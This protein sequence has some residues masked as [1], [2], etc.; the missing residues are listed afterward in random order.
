MKEVLELLWAPFSEVGLY[1]EIRAIKNGL[2]NQFFMPTEEPELHEAYAQEQSRLGFDVYF[3]VLPRVR[4]SGTAG[5]CV[6]TSAVLWSDVDAKRFGAGKL[7]ALQAV[8]DLGPVPQVLVDSGGG[9]HAYWLLAEPVPFDQARRAME[10]IAQA[11][12]G[13]ATYDA[14]RV[15][16]VPGTV[17]YKYRNY[18]RVLRL[19]ATAPR[20]RISDFPVIEMRP[21]PN[22]PVPKRPSSQQVDW[23]GAHEIPKWLNVLIEKG[24]PRGQRSEASYKVAIWLFLAGQQW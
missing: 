8:N 1:G 2:V 10:Y 24:A 7:G 13:D 19:D 9:L 15:L 18:A 12:N 20:Y 6:S 14:A 22:G 16:R 11:V 3:G 4:K 5:D 17:N 23:T 21:N